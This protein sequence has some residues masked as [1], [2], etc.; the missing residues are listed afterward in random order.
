VAAME[1]EKAGLA[2]AGGDQRAVGADREQLGRPLAGVERA[3]V[4]VQLGPPVGG[5]VG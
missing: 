5:A 2:A 4:D 3:P 1:A